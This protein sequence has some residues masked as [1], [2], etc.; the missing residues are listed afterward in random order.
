MFRQRPPFDAKAATWHFDGLPASGVIPYADISPIYGADRVVNVVEVQRDDGPTERRESSTWRALLGELGLSLNTIHAT[1]EAARA[2]ADR[3]LARSAEPRTIIESIDLR[4]RHPDVP[5]GDVL[6]VEL[7]D[8]VEVTARPTGAGDI[9]VQRAKVERIEHA[10]DW[11]GWD[12]TTR[13][14][15]DEWR[16]LIP[17]DPADDALQ[18]P[19]ALVWQWESADSDWADVDWG[20]VASNGEA[21]DPVKVGQQ[22]HSGTFT[23]W[24]AAVSFDL[25]SW[26]GIDWSL[27][28][29][30]ELVATSDQA[31]VDNT[32]DVEAVPASSAIESGWTGW[33]PSVI[34]AP[35]ETTITWT[36]AATWVWPP[37]PE[38]F[39]VVAGSPNRYLI[40]RLHSSRQ[41]TQD[42]PTGDEM[43]LF[44]PS[45]FR[46][47]LVP[48]TE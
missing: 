20:A 36:S 25:A 42:Q 29:G 33:R 6:D 16:I 37:T 15:L 7:A 12:W 13:F 21:T 24:Q 14:G 44:D 10:W 32:F 5:T 28:A 11:Q 2:H 34:L 47:R 4:P 8:V 26:Q 18:L 31:P 1:P 43:A 19:A 48:R 40:V 46:L 27:F 45:S 41:R 39:D 9:I 17:D 23:I 22:L 30:V 3:V 38:F 35:G